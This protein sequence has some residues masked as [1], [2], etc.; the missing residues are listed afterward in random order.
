MERY[1]ANPNAPQVHFIRKGGRVI[2]IISGRKT[3]VHPRVA[4]HL[5]GTSEEPWL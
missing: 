4:A 1:R 5:A 3:G 2:P